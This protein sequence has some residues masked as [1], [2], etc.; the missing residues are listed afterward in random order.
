M[1]LGT[2]TLL[3]SQDELATA[4]ERIVG[5]EAGA[6]APEVRVLA[7]DEDSAPG[8]ARR[9]ESVPVPAELAVLMATA[10]ADAGA[11]P[12]S[13]AAAVA[14][15]NEAIRMARESGAAE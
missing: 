14:S 15:L 12:G 8:L 6:A 3:F 7:R 4:A 9:L 5:A 11:A 1:G 2:D 10:A 13:D